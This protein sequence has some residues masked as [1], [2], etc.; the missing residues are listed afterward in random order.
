MLENFFTLS[1]AIASAVKFSNSA[2]FPNFKPNTSEK[3]YPLLAYI[4]RENYLD[5]IF[6]VNWGIFPPH[7]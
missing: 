6:S 7:P 5:I 4:I 2:C 1:K 3:K